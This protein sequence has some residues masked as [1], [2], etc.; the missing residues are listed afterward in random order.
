MEPG[1]MPPQ[2]NP[3]GQVSPPAPHGPGAPHRQRGVP[4]RTGRS[5]M[6]AHTSPTGQAPPQMPTVPPHAGTPVG[7]QPQLPKG[8]E[9]F[10]RHSVPAGHRPPP[11]GHVSPQGCV[12]STHRQLAK[13][14]AGAQVA[15]AGQSPAQVKSSAIAQPPASV[16]V[17]VVG[18]PPSRLPS[19][20]S[21]SA[22]ASAS[23][24]SNLPATS[25]RIVAALNRAQLREK[26]VS[27]RI[28]MPPCGSA[29]G[30]P[31][32]R[33][34]SVMSRPSRKT[35]DRT[36]ENA[37]GASGLTNFWTSR[38]PSFCFH[39]GLPGLFGAYRT[40]SPSAGEKR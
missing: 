38:V 34:R 37:S 13:S 22:E 17:V 7:K 28:P 19:P 39:P 4:P 18:G 14:G 27:M 40:A 21:A 2:P 35:S 10:S 26:P 6:V 5:K 36:A 25:V 11:T 3:G 33:A 31:V 30:S 29:S 23:L 9:L 20:Q 32:A 16:V 24:A 15:P 1:G 12:A 8:N